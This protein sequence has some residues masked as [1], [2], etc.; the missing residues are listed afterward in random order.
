MSSKGPGSVSAVWHAGGSNGLT[1]HP[2]AQRPSHQS[3]L[4]PEAPIIILMRALSGPWG[5]VVVAA[6]IN[7]L[8]LI[9]DKTRWSGRAFK[10]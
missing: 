1:H 2:G 8:T 5:D 10:W 9:V 4:L 6:V 3:G 7:T